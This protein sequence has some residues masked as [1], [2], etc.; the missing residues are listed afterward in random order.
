MVRVVV[1]ALL[2]LLA[3]SGVSGAQPRAPSDYRQTPAVLAHYPAVPGVTLDS[4]A[5]RTAEPSLTTAIMLPLM[6]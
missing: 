4:P 5:F 6:V 2:S 1:A 3:L